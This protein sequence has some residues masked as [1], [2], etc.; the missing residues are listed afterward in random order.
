MPRA[1]ALFGVFACFSLPLLTFAQQPAIQARPQTARQAI[2]EM[3]NGDEQ[4]AFKHLTEEVQQSMKAPGSKAG[5]SQAAAGFLREL[6]QGPNSGTEVFD[7][8]PV[9]LSFSEAKT[10][11]KL[12][13]HVDSDDLT[14]D[15]DRLTLSLHEFRDGLEI[16]TPLHLISQIEVG[17]KRQK[18][19]WRLNDITIS[20]K[21]PLGDPNLM[22]RLGAGG[23]AG[24]HLAA[25]PF[26]VYPAQNTTKAKLDAEST[27]R[28]LAIAEGMYASMHPETGFTCSL[29]D[30]VDQSRATL[31]GMGVD[32]AVGSG[33]LNGYSFT[34]SGCNG[35]PAGSFQMA[36]EPVAAGAGVK[37]F[38]TDATHNIRISEDGRASTCLASGKPE[39][40]GWAAHTVV[41]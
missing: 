32:R 13:L 9:L 39:Q 31:S 38:C 18:G 3:I 28:M 4:A 41:K 30:L 19:I 34:I 14:A 1:S 7:T 6:R 16:D 17:M 26:G 36:A 11:E 24:I 23:V 5:V 40:P 21:V 22:K 27:L 2:V 20:A 12:E 35:T 33:S 29:S 25:T 8:G 15:E 37:A 10:H